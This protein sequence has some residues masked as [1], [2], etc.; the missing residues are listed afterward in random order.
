MTD[1]MATTGTTAGASGLLWLQLHCFFG[2]FVIAG[3]ILLIIWAV[4]YLSGNALKSLTI[5]L[6]IIGIIG[7][8][9]TTIPAMNGVKNLIGAWRGEQPMMMNMPMMERMMDMMMNSEGS[10]QA[11]HHP[12]EDSGSTSSTM[13][14]D[15]SPQ[16][17][18]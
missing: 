7:S 13:E 15:D 16:M 4:K 11:E 10:S 12:A 1:M 9:L 5:W 3:A 14:M 18:Q 6:L 8:L 2:V 17:D